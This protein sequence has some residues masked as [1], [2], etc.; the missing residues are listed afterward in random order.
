MKLTKRKLDQTLVALEDMWE[1][2]PPISGEVIKNALFR[3]LALP[4]DNTTLNEI[5]D[6]C[7]STVYDGGE[8]NTDFAANELSELFC[9]I[10]HRY[11]KLKTVL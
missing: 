11:L 1:D 8:W 5:W 9:L 10:L 7:L 3:E 6:D 4:K 2:D